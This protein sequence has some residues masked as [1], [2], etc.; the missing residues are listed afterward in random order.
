MQL[1]QSADN[2]GAF[3][4]EVCGSSRLNSLAHNLRDI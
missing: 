3:P 2:M 4:S 1:M